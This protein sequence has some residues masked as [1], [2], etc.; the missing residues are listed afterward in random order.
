MN[1]FFKYIHEVESYL[2]VIIIG[3]EK[4]GSTSELIFPVLSSFVAA[5]PRRQGR[6]HLRFLRSF[7]R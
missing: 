2:S 5:G 1:N 6:G 7:P 4:N 3:Y